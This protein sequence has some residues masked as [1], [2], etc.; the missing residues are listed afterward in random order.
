MSKNPLICIV[1]ITPSAYDY[2]V[3]P[4]LQGELPASAAGPG[5]DDPHVSGQAAPGPGEE[6]DSVHAP[7]KG[8]AV[9]R[10]DGGRTARVPAPG[11]CG[12]LQHLPVDLSTP[13]SQ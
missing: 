5:R 4:L 11:Y 12:Q 9:R 3:I 2:T 6:D 1:F 8:G 13:P 7:K 10:G